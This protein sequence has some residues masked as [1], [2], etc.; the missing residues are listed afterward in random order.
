MSFKPN[1]PQACEGTITWMK[2]NN[3]TDS[4]EFI[5]FILRSEQ[6][7]AFDAN[8]EGFI[9][10]AVLNSLDGFSFSGEYHLD[11]QGF[12]KVGAIQA[13]LYSNQANFILFGTWIENSTKYQ[14]IC[15]FRAV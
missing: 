12:T 3:E 6:E 7:L 15:R 14:L 9:Y 4:T 11:E 8:F 10:S 5:Q 1:Y 13:S 2:E